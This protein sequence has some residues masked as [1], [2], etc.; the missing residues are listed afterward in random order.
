MAVQERHPEMVPV[1]RKFEIASDEEGV[2]ITGKVPAEYFR[3]GHRPVE[4]EPSN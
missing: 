3:R 1:I 4:A 2:S